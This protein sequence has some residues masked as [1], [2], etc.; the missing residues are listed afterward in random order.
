MN[1][2][3]QYA[4]YAHKYDTCLVE[5]N[6]TRYVSVTPTVVSQSQLRRLNDLGWKNRIT[7]NDLTKSLHNRLVR[8]K[9]VWDD[10]RLE[11]VGQ[12]LAKAFEHCNIT[13][14]DVD[15]GK[16][17]RAITYIVQV[18]GIYELMARIEADDPN[19]TVTFSISRN[20]VHFYTGSDGLDS[21]GLH[22]QKFFAKV[23]HRVSEVE[24][25][26]F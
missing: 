4:A 8:K 19:E 1:M 23:N 17:F 11:E 9:V 18:D 15:Y 26:K 12:R 10:L 2:M 25:G 24:Y 3:V 14:F 5:D 13:A 6:P 20:N 7:V 21:F 22:V 16:V